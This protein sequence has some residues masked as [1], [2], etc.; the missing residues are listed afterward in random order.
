MGN[1]PVTLYAQITVTSFTP[2]SGPIGTTVTITGTNFNTTPANN[3]VFFGA[4]AGTVSAA[5]ASTL[6]IMVPSGANY[7]DATVTDLVTKLTAYADDQFIVTFP[8]G[9]AINSGSFGSNV[10]FT[11]GSSPIAVSVGDFN[12]DGKADLAIVNNGNN[13]ISLLQNTSMMESISFA[14][15]TDFPT[16]ISPQS[17]AVGDLNGDGKLD[18]AVISNGADVVSVFKNT[19]VGIE[20]LF[21]VRIDFPTGNSPQDVSIADMDGDGA[22]DIIVTNSGT[23]TISILR[24]SS[25]AGGISFAAKTDYTTGLSPKGLRIADLDGDKKPDIISANFSSG[26]V[27]VLRNTST[28][29]S[30]SLDPKIDLI[31]GSGTHGV[32]I[33]DLDGDG[34]NDITVSNTMSNTLSIFRNTSSTGSV[35]FAAKADIPTG[36]T[37]MNVSIGDI[38]GD[39]IP[40]LAVTNNT[41]NDISV[42][43]NTSTNG[44]ISLAPKVDF[45]TGNAPIGLSIGDLDGDGRPELIATNGGS[46]SVMPNLVFEGPVMTSTNTKSICSGT[47]INLSLSF[48]TSST[49]TWIANDNT[50]TTGEST[51][52]QTNT[53]LNDTIIN[54]TSSAQTVTY[55]VTPTSLAES[56]VGTPQMVQVIVNPL[57]DAN[58]GADTVLTCDNPTLTLTGTSVSSPVTYQWTTPDNTISNTQTITASSSGIYILTVTNSITLCTNTDSML[59]SF[60]TIAPII[61]C[62]LNYQ[63]TDCIPGTITINGTTDDVTDSI[64][65]FGPGIPTDNPALISNQNNYLLWSK[66]NSNGCISTETVTVTISTVSP[67][68]Q[69]QV[70]MDTTQVIDIL[71]TLT[72]LND[73]VLLNFSGSTAGSKI[74]IIRPSPMNDTVSNNTVAT[75]PGIY[76]AII[77]DTTT[78]CNGAG[79]LFELKINV[80]LPQ[81]IPPAIIPEFNCSILSAVLNGT[82]G[83]PNSILN[84]TGANNFSSTNPA[85]VTQ[86][87]TYVLSVIDP[88]NGCIKSDTITLIYQN[89]LLINGSMDTTICK[90]ETVQL[91]VTPL[92]GTPNYNYSWN[93]NAGNSASVN[94]NPTDTTRFIVNVTDSAGCIGLDTVY[95]NVPDP[96]AD[97]ILTFHLCDPAVPNGLIQI[98][99]SNGLL[100]Y[101]YSITNGQ[102]YQSSPIFLNLPFGNY[103]LLIKDAM[104]CIHSDS[105]TISTLSQKPHPDFIVNTNMMQADTFV[106]VDISNPRPDSVI[107]TFPSTV[108][109]LDN[110][111]FAPI[112]VSADTGAVD[113]TMQTH[114]GGCIMFLTK[115]IQFIKAD[116]IAPSPNGNGIEALTLF[117]NPNTGQFSIEVKLYKKQTFAIYV[118][119]SQGIEQARVVI[120][121][122]NYSLNAISIPNPI[123]GTY[124]LKVIAEYDSKSK[125]IVV[126]Q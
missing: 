23:N 112:I 11:A 21:D 108:T 40:D 117:P 86:P 36:S 8:C 32:T 56:C 15:K 26:N 24:N 79:L 7:Q 70:S 44:A 54:T 93:N 66:R 100:P 49:Y 64:K 65:W 111:P 116:T 37:P 125:T 27:S 81:L 76:K 12:G 72:C 96:I 113:I 106:V 92:G 63:I 118:Y 102:F 123:P 58:A 2:G 4:T 109:V 89:V 20:V 45:I 52:T 29:G 110:N 61:T 91:N 88:N 30:I 9:G 67:I 80:T 69:I 120:S 38:D 103:P 22:P 14:P 6:T 55:M 51:T 48:N 41:S 124:V 115:T 62:P 10:N 42:F 46:L 31:A 57:P 94:V 97:S 74:R 47:S 121:E 33:G 68:I 78:G 3:K 43:K 107:W 75:L 53:A 71:D 13:T 83:T 19:S 82:S 77:T 59:V 16:G 28:S 60:D 90:G 122:L 73:S 25:N 50:G 95:V 5:S 17:I 119:N 85:T 126:T 105:A 84:W 18:L 1:W 35:S 87:G 99:A 39:G 101:Q 34:K 104:N 98:F 114:F